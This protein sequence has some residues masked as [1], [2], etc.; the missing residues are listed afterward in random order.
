MAAENARNLLVQ[1]RSR[2]QQRFNYITK[3][4]ANY[5]R[6]LLLDKLP[7]RIEG[8]D[9]SNLQG[10]EA[11]ASMVVFENGVTKGSDYRRFKIRTVEGP[12]DFAMLQEAVRRRFRKGL[13]NARTWRRRKASSPV[14]G[15]VID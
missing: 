3:M 14:P 6:R 11:V 5:N 13:R 8:F 2:E 1:E 4:L 15:F 10:Q 7:L 9:I 12:N